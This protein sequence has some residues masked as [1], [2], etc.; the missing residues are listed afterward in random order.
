M[1]KRTKLPSSQVNGHTDLP[2]DYI[3]EGEDHVMLFDVQDTIDLAVSNV[4]TASASTTQNGTPA[5]F[6][7]ID[8]ALKCLLGSAVSSF[9]TDTEISHRNTGQ[10]RHRELQK[11]DGGLDM[12]LDDMTF[13]APGGSSWDQF[14][15]NEQKF[16][17]QTTYDEDEYTTSIDRSHPDYNRRMAEAARVAREIETST[18]SNAHVAEER[19]QNADRGDG[20]D[21]EDK[22][23]G[24]RR[25][26]PQLARGGAG[27]YVPPSRRPITSAPTVPGAPFDPAIISLAKPVPQTTVDRK[28]VV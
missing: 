7:Y 27:S 22:Y 11:W 4:V 14:A 23:S 9:R 12:S 18:A 10:P 28:S 17:T 5:P 1:V 2:D 13:E 8:P 3:G 21:E 16:G 20:L 6:L 19:R 15:A 25:D 26:A 24:V